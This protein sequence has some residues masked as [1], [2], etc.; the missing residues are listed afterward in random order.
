LTTDAWSDWS[1]LGG[2]FTTT[3]SAIVRSDGVVELFA[4]DALGIAWHDESDSSIP[5]GWSGFR[6]LTTR[7][8][9][10]GGADASMASQPAPRL[11]S[12]PMP[13]RLSDGHVELFATTPTGALVRSVRS[14][15][16]G[17]FTT[18]A[19]GVVGEPAPTTAG[20][21]T[22]VFVRS[23]SNVVSH[24]TITGQQVGALTPSGLTS[25]VD[26]F[27]WA[28]TDQTLEV[29]ALRTA[30]STIMHATRDTL[31]QLS[32]WSELGQVVDACDATPTTVPTSDAGSPSAPS[33]DGD[34]GCATRP[35]SASAGWSI[36]LLL[37]VIRIVRR[38]CVS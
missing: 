33:S 9:G 7:D 28:R 35:G 29:F 12:R 31:G 36:L 14:S 3:P 6:M 25:A 21:I 32:A 2:A 26:P 20:G 4:V 17:P 19:S 5:G 24:V 18:V 15:V 13:L 30:D 37:A 22:D 27:A 8:L 1:S 34:S 11:A 23:S 10:D 16:W 38:R